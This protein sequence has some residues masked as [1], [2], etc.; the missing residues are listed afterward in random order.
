[1]L[2]RTRLIYL[3]FLVS[4]S[5]VFLMPNSDSHKRDK[6]FWF[7][8]DKKETLNQPKK[9]FDYIVL[10]EMFQKL[11]SSKAQNE[12]EFKTMTSKK[13]K[14]DACLERSCTKRKYNIGRPLQC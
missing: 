12:N 9:G 1:M 10:L 13:R 14:Q 7:R 4:L 2:L 5:E 11:I 3:M 8:F 6:R